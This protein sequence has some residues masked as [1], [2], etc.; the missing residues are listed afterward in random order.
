MTFNG[1][2]SYSHAADGRLAPAVQ[3][4]LHRLAKP[5]HRRRALWIFRDQ[6]G[7]SVTPG[8]WSSIQTALD[9]SEF[10]VLL[11][12]PEAAQ[13]PWVNR[14]IEHWIATKS[15]DR[16]LPVVTDGEWAWDGDLGDFSEG[17][18]AVPPALQG[19]FSEEPFFLD[20]RWARGSEHLSLQHSRFRDAIAQL[21]APMH[22]VSTDELEGEDVRQ[23]RRARR[24]GSGAAA[25]LVVLALVAALTGVSAVRNAERAKSAA[26][27]A[28]RQQQ[29]ANGQRDSAERSAEEALRQEALAKEQ[30][31]RAAQAAAEA[32]QAE[33]LAREQQRLADQAAADAR[34]QQGLAA[35]ATNRT[36][37]QQ[38]LAAAASERAQR[39][40]KEAKRLDR[41]AA[42][43]RRLAQ[44]AASAAALQQAKADAQQR[45]AVSRRL[46]NQAG[47]AIVD[48]PPT[49]L[50]LGAAAQEINPDAVTR[51]QLT[52]VVTATN[53]AGTVGNTTQAVYGPDGALVAIG[54]D[55]RVS[56]WNVADPRRPDRIATLRDTEPAVAAEFLRLSPDGRTLAIV[57]EQRSMVLWDI[58]HQSR[59]VRLGPLPDVDHA[60]AMEFSGDGST[61]V[62]G[63]AAGIVTL[64]GMTGGTRPTRLGGLTDIWSDQPILDLAISPDGRFMVADRQR[65]AASYDMIDPAHP[66]YHHAFDINLWTSY[67]QFTFSPDGTKLAAVDRDNTVVVF[68]I[69]DRPSGRHDQDEPS[70]GMVPPPPMPPDEEEENQPIQRLVG[71][72]GVVNSV[73]FSPD[74]GLLAAG[75]S[76][77]TAKVWDLKTPPTTA[78]DRAFTSVQAR[79]PITTVSFDPDAKILVTGDKSGMATLWNVTPPGAPDPLA[80]LAVPGGQALATVLRPD[81]RLVA[82]RSDGTA[83]T[84]NT[85]DPGHPARG[86]DVALHSGAISAVAYSTDHRRV[87]V[88]ATGTS[89]LTVTDTNRPNRPVTLAVLPQG[90]SGA[91]PMAFSPDAS[92]LAVTVGSRSLMLWDVADL[93]RPALLSKLDGTG[94][95]SV[96]FRPDGRTL[97]VESSGSAVTLWNLADRSAPVRSATLAGHSA[98]VESVAFSPDGRYLVS[99]SADRTA[100][101]WAVADPTRPYRL[102]TLAGHAGTVSSVAFS[103]DGRTLA[104]GGTDYTAILWDTTDPAGPIR[105]ATLGT[106]RG[107]EVRE[108]TFGR[109]GRTLAV[110][111]QPAGGRATITLWSYKKLNSL[112]AAPATYACAIT[113]RGLTTSEWARFIPEFRYRRTCPTDVERPAVMPRRAGQRRRSPDRYGQVPRQEFRLLGD[114]DLRDP[115]EP[116]GLRAGRGTGD[117]AAGHGRLECEPHRPAPVA[118]GQHLRVLD[119]ADLRAHLDRDTDL[120]HRHPAYRGD[121]RLAEADRAARQVPLPPARL[122]VPLDQQDPLIGPDHDLDGQAG[123]PGVDLIEFFR[124]QGHF[125]VVRL[126]PRNASSGPCTAGGTRQMRCRC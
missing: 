116:G 1:F 9:G 26:A 103:P 4:G 13:S 107:D 125:I 22:G 94:L 115:G 60:N 121:Q 35:Q 85:A 50:M 11:A 119:V 92:T 7:L 87:A 101:L 53:Y 36:R 41:L 15:A 83:S 14:E 30:Q 73:A 19:V 76:N 23:H 12:S 49:A 79:G 63:D 124:R 88:V 48:D 69:T 6:T 113:G 100:V 78:S 66:I 61:F 67:T 42:E 43:Q 90:V 25:T 84:W 108:V 68:D 120:G 51:R 52:G 62:T 70:G 117:P 104:T 126:H 97:A 105:F 44:Q 54:S 82:A 16:I 122:D 3:R 65:Q 47:A 123:H 10:F 29:V 86:A 57:D 74:G 80:A 38:R 89:T 21:A 77:G 46:M 39:M 20:L 32:D 24:L 33:R 118:A 71:L 17:S 2:I 31:A 27:E 98:S 64:W 114:R 110:T 58:T 81:G 40:Q 18:T 96:A 56:L 95:G 106:A 55:G 5:W 93:A 91:N 112:R 111:G 72:T 45:I 37:E 28:M 8:L 75:D 99:G 102:A 109:D 34:R 59:P